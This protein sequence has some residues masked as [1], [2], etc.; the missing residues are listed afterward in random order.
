VKSIV[1]IDINE[2]NL[3][4]LRV[5]RNECAEFMTRSNA[6]V[7]REGQI[8][9]FDSI[10]KNEIK[11]YLFKNDI[12]VIGY[13]LIRIED[14]FL[15]SGGLM[16][17]LRGQG[18]GESLFQELINKCQEIDKDKPIDLEVLRSNVRAYKLYQKLGFIETKSDDKII[19]MRKREN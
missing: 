13:G 7:N 11:P 10:N 18:L 15:L 9:W 8:T 12:G 2:N 17:E 3:E 1:L 16:P 19:S 5:I 6:Y 14:S 4:I